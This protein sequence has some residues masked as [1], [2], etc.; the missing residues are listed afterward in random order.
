M[1]FID[2][3][4]DSFQPGCDTVLASDILVHYA[5][6]FVDNQLYYIQ[7]CLMKRDDESGMESAGLRG[8]YTGQKTPKVDGALSAEE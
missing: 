5:C 6:L 2:V 7:N 1:V 4:K 3:C 8:V